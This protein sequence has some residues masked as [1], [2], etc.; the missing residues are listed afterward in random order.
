MTRAM[1]VA[2]HARGYMSAGFPVLPLFGVDEEGVCTCSKRSDCTS[3]GK[4]PY[5]KAVPHGLDSASTEPSDL[6]EWIAEGWQ[7][8]LGIRLDGHIVFDLDDGDEGEAAFA[9]LNQRLGE[10]PPT[11]FQRSGSGR[12]LL[13]RLPNGVT[14]GNSTKNLGNPRHVDVRGGEAGYIVVEPSI[15]HSGNAYAWD[16]RTQPIADLPMDW[17]AVLAKKPSAPPNQAEPKVYDGTAGGTRYGLAALNR[18]AT[19]LAA[20]EEGGRN[21]ALN[22][23]AFACGSLV[24][25]GELDEQH[26]FDTLTDAA[27]ECG[28]DESETAQTLVSGMD[29]GVTEPRSAPFAED[30]DKPPQG[31]PSGDERPFIQSVSEWLANAPD[32]PPWIVKGLTA[33]ACVTLL[34][35]SPKVGKS[36]FVFSLLRAIQSGEPFLGRPTAETQVLYLTEEGQAT[37]KPKADTFAIDEDKHFVACSWDAD[38]RS[39]ETVLDE[40]L[41]ICLQH[42]L[43]LVIVDTWAKWVRFK[44]DEENDASAVASRI[45]PLR[46]K[47][48]KAGIGVLIVHHHSKGV[49]D[50]AFGAAARG[51][52]ALTADVDILVDMW[53]SRKE[54]DDGSRIISITGRCVEE[55][56]LGLSVDLD[57]GD[58]WTDETVL[59]SVDSKQR[60]LSVLTDQ[61]Q[62]IDTI[63]ELSHMKRNDVIAVVQTLVQAGVVAKE[64]SGRRGDPFT[65]KKPA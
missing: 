14:L 7:G 31:E 1:L 39:W 63:R 3:P 45:A 61:P 25:G 53:R 38:Q 35:G 12:H 55:E 11:R 48:C 54:A 42:N 59:S 51:S 8:N 9:T 44:P 10:L 47:L 21:E 57:S 56:K 15:H 17:V 60:I 62:N 27:L 19:T 52:T 23:A 37:F 30:A 58:I 34:S 5:A 13:Y 6:D 2:R 22:R 20:T 32:E 65:Y 64:G 43:K 26:V 46:E 33:E 16:D 41:V 28:L 50:P 4:H 40:A 24:A 29:A 18:E 36:T 49:A